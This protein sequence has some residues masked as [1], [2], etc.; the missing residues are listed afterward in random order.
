MSRPSFLLSKVNN[1]GDAIAFLPTVAGLREAFPESP[2]DLVCTPKTA[3]IFSSS[4]EHVRTIPVAYQSVRGARGLLQVPKVALRL[5][6]GRHD[7]ALLSHDETKF[8]HALTLAVMAR[9]RI[10]FD[11]VNRSWGRLLTDRLPFVPG[12]NIVDLNFD[13]VRR[14]TDNPTLRPRRTPLGYEPRD[15][16]IV[17]QKLGQ[18]G[19]APHGA[20]VALQPFASLPYKRWDL[21]RYFAVA[22][23][24]TRELGVP[25]VV[26]AEKDGADLGGRL[27]V[28]D[29]TIPQLAAL[30]ERASLLIGNN[31]G[32]M[33]IASAMGTPT[34]VLH[35]PSA[36]EWDAPWS[37]VPHRRL[38]AEGLRCI[39]C[40]QIGR[41]IG[42]CTNPDDPGG[43]M[44][45]ISVDTAFENAKAMLQNGRGVAA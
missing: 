41:L 44:A 31:S 38:I 33:H 11:L 43:C 36:F 23:R 28:A 25:A 2:I 16:E 22:D 35:G 6:I 30:L 17:E 32:P 39:P 40:E 26:V 5:G 12:R 42:Y 7:F 4:V 29:L 8:A 9:R 18:I 37:D 24:I 20:F 13:L 14:A 10:G 15:R 1:L 19:I 34:L 45:G 27:F 21:A 3:A